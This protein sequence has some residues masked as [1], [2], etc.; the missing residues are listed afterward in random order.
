MTHTF[1][2]VWTSESCGTF[3]TETATAIVAECSTVPNNNTFFPRILCVAI[4]SATSRPL[5]A[6]DFDCCLSQEQDIPL[7]DVLHVC[8]VVTTLGTVPFRVRGV[9][10]IALLSCVRAAALAAASKNAKAYAFV[11]VGAV[12]SSTLKLAVGPEPRHEAASLPPLTI[13]STKRND[14]AASRSGP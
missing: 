5:R 10:T 9:R 8:T 7:D 6:A 4:R 13:G 3:R 1:H 12:C 14:T 2:V 11:C